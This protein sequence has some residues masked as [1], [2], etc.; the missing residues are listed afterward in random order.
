MKK[1]TII[2]TLLILYSAGSAQTNTS[3][4]SLSQY[5]YDTCQYLQQFAGEWRYVNGNDTIKVYFRV[6]KDSSES[7]KFVMTRLLGW[8]EYKQGNVIVESNYQN[9]FDVLPY[10]VDTVANTT[11]S[12]SLIGSVPICNSSI[13]TLVGSIIDFAQNK[14]LHIVKAVI[15][16]SGS[17]I[18]MNWKQKHRD[19]FGFLTGAT[20]MTLPKEFI[21]TKQ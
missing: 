20:G 10:F 4:Y 13:D 12:I 1:I 21:L 6:H 18:T 5:Y 17:T 19:G 8:I 14:E 2:I 9:R 3:K 16:T 15:N 7:M 11:H